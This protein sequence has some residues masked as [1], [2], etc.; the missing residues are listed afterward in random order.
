MGWAMLGLEVAQAAGAQ[1][2]AEVKTRLAKTLVAA[3]NND[4]SLDYQAD[5]NPASD[6]AANVAKAGSGLQGLAFTGAAGSD[7]KVIAAIGYITRNWDATVD[8]QSF[9]CIS[10][11]PTPH[12]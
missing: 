5:A 6:N 2:P 10:G 4:G 9:L 11:S 7:P 8:P 12:Q 3:L 1:I